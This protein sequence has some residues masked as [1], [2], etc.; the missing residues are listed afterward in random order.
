[1]NK[2]FKVFAMAVMLIMGSQ[3]IAQTHGTMFLG[4]SFPMGDFAKVN[5]LSSTALW[6][7][8]QQTF[9]GAGIGFNAGLKWDFGVG[10]PGLA[11]VLSVDGFYNGSNSDMKQCYKEVVNAADYLNGD[12]DQTTPKYINVPAMLGLRYTFNL[13]PQLAIYAEGAAG[14]NARFITDYTL[15]YTDLLSVKH[16]DTESYSTAYTFAYQAGLG[17][18]VSRNLVIGCSLY[19]LGGAAVKGEGTVKPSLSNG[20]YDIERGTLKPFM[21]LGRIG[22]RL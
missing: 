15:K 10:I 3:A 19:N 1:M 14:G 11:V 18:E 6:G 17:I 16:T 8:E 4:A 13:T 22:F 7:D 2:L 12:V 20:T 21:V 5:D 9:G